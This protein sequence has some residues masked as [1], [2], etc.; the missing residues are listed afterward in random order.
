MSLEVETKIV[1]AP[2]VLDSRP[3]CRNC[4]ERVDRL[5]CSGCGQHIADHNH[6]LREFIAEFFRE[7]LTV[8]SKFLRTLVPL[9]FKPGYLTREWVQGRRVRYITPLKL[10]LSL[11][12]LL[13]LSISFFPDRIIQTDSDSGTKNHVGLT[14][15]PKA[16]KKSAQKSDDDPVGNFLEK[17]LSSLSTNDKAKQLEFADKFTSHLPTANLI[18][19]PIFAL[20]FKLLYLR[21]SRFYVEHLAFALHYYAFVSLAAMVCIV[22]NTPFVT[23]P[24][25]IWGALYLLLAMKFN[26]QQGF[27]KTFL[28]CFFF[29]MFYLT[30][31][32]FTS[33][34]LVILTAIQMKGD[35]QP[36]SRNPQPSKVIAA[37]KSHS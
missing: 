37:T 12:A 33:L 11:S 14:V 36:A 5:Y 9:C 1:E 10:Y 13:F 8:D 27:V 29:G 17:N 16:S 32:G 30:A 6:S 34:G 4:G 3:I 22:A 18:L 2:P 24:I 26:Y 15:S 25:A 28:K 21:R 7:F 35:S 31:V 23:V 20:I 19:L